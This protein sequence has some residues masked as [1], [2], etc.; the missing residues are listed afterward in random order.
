MRGGSR[1]AIAG[2]GITLGAGLAF[3][4]PAQ[5]D[6]ETFTVNSLDDG[7]AD[8]CTTLANGCT[9]RD[10]MT[11]AEDGDTTDLDTIVFDSSITGSPGTIPLAGTQLPEIHEPLYIDGPGAA[12]IDITGYYAGGPSYSRIFSVYAGGD[13]GVTIEGLKLHQGNAYNSS[14]GAIRIDDAVIGA[15]EPDLTVKNSE[16]SGNKAGQGAGIYA[17]RASVTV[18]NST[19]T[20]NT[21]GTYGYTGGGGIYQFPGVTGTVTIQDSVISGNST[22]GDQSRGGGINALGTTTIQD[23]VISGNYTTGDYAFGG[24]AFLAG[25][26][27]I[28]D[29]GIYDNHTEGVYAD[30]GGITSGAFRSLDITSSTIYD[31]YALGTYADGGGVSSPSGDNPTLESSTVYA[32]SV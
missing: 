7:P 18:Q 6:V 22:G 8:A 24:G 11:A 29:S 4:A 32:N 3:A 30:G 28:E 31:N 23:S 20:D 26:A 13:V 16:I 21:T 25:D 10:A 14:G 1:R 15:P 19:I 17:F 5:A 9:L 2:A 12:V 27:T